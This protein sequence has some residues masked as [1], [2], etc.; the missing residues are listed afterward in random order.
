[1]LCRA[2]IAGDRFEIIYPGGLG[3]PPGE[4]GAIAKEDAAA[5]LPPLPKLDESLTGDAFCEVLAGFAVT[6]RKDGGEYLFY[7]RFDDSRPEA[8]SA[9]CPSKP[10]EGLPGRSPR[11]GH[12]A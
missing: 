3:K 8:G 10:G 2:K 12:V 9:P 5:S 1:M 11:A 6:Q 4:P 7:R